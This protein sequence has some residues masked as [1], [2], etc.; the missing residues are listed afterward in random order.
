M[1]DAIDEEIERFIERL[2]R[3][4]NLSEKSLN[5]IREKLEE[6]RKERSG[7]L[8][9]EGLRSFFEDLNFFSQLVIRVIRVF[10]RGKKSKRDL[11][12][13]EFQEDIRLSKWA[14]SK[15]L[16]FLNNKTSVKST[17]RFNEFL[18]GISKFQKEVIGYFAGDAEVIEYESGKKCLYDALFRVMDELDIWSVVAIKEEKFFSKVPWFFLIPIL[19]PIIFLLAYLRARIVL[20]YL[21]NQILGMYDLQDRV[22]IPRGA[23][24]IVPS[25][26]KKLAKKRN[27]DFQIVEKYVVIHE[28]IHDLQTSIF[29]VEDYRKTLAKEFFTKKDSSSQE[30][31]G[32]LMTVIE[33]HA[34]FFT[35]KL[36]KELWPE[37]QFRKKKGFLQKM[38]NKAL[39]LEG[40]TKQYE[41]GSH[42]IGYLYQKGGLTMAN[43][44]LTNLPFSMDEIKNPETYLKRVACLNNLGRER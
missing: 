14:V 15:T 1:G 8:S 3:E 32:A 39:G 26:I 6:I 5:S 4:F 13:Q 44:P 10:R 22:P 24:R 18:G 30:K 23:I 28:S 20:T 7:S 29:P 43:L 12:S 9:E 17:T 2:R 38:V 34:E 35:N 21:S 33:G 31:L 19:S 42:F 37:I 36:A 16:A 41:I 25:N 27:L 11:N 40:K